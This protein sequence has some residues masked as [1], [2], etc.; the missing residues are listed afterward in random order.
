MRFVVK[1]LSKLENFK[2]KYENILVKQ[3]EIY[4]N[5]TFKK[6]KMKIS[7]NGQERKK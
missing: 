4:Y 7:E 2:M 5:K 1:K 3:I 6:K